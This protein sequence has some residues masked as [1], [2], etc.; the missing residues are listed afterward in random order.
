MERRGKR[1]KNK[2]NT[3]TMRDDDNGPEVWLGS[4]LELQEKGWD[5]TRGKW[6]EAIYKKNL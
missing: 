6:M 3:E 5:K 1:E 4:F 2:E